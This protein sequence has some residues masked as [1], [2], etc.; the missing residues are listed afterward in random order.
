MTFKT[1]SQ[2]IVPIDLTYVQTFALKLDEYDRDQ[3]QS[4]RDFGLE[5]A[6][7][8]A[9]RQLFDDDHS[10]IV[11]LDEE[12]LMLCIGKTI[13]QHVHDQ[14]GAMTSASTREAGGTIAA[15]TVLDHRT[16]NEHVLHETP[17]LE[18][19]ADSLEGWG[20]LDNWFYHQL[21]DALAASES[22]RRRVR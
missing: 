22:Y 20:D 11:S 8:L 16:D 19:V 15:L 17:P 1:E 2:E 10:S 7:E 3:D 14:G 13:S 6:A 21:T 4:V 12:A 9:E 5:A 18:E